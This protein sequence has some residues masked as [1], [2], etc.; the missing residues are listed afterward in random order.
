MFVCLFLICVLPDSFSKT[1]IS[2]VAE[3]HHQIHKRRR[4][5][6]DTF[7]SV[8]AAVGLPSGTCRL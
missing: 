6:P 3:I 4:H 8:V 5:C 7:L 2:I 1:K